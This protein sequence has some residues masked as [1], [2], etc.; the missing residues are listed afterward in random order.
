MPQKLQIEE[1]N[2]LDVAAFKA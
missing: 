1:M 2:R